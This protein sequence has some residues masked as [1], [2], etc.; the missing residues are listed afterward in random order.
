MVCGF[1]IRALIG[2]ACAAF[3]LGACGGS[4]TATTSSA[5]SPSV[6]LVSPIATATSAA[7]ADLRV[8][9]G[10]H[11]IDVALQ[12]WAVAQPSPHYPVHAIKLVLLKTMPDPWP[13]NPF[14]GAD[15]KPGASRGEYQYSVA[16]NKKRCRVTARLSDGSLYAEQT[17]RIQ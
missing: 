4:A 1:A 12:S 2:V 15:M 14:T 8:K 6:S 11:A 5:P 17:L 16:T 13:S 7:Q 10:V 9:E 3:A